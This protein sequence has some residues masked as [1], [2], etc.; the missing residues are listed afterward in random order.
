[1]SRFGI[2][3]ALAMEGEAGDRGT[4][5]VIE[6]LCQ[7]LGVPQEDGLPVP[8]A[9]MGTERM[10]A[11]LNALAVNWLA[12]DGV[13]FQAVERR[14]GMTAA[15]QVNDA[16]WEHFSP[17]EAARIKA[18]TG[19]PANGGL[20]ALASAFIH[21]LYGSINEQEVFFE[22]DGSLVLRM[23]KCRVQAARQRKGLADY[24][25][26]SGGE[27]EYAGFART[28]DPRIACQCIACPPD[29]HPADWFCAWRFTIGATP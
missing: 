23:T 29:P 7:T 27:V 21:R 18:A 22:A 2:E 25:C 12:L 28:I 3:Q 5:I 9:A 26:R 19:L 4:A 11:L 20:E 6:R 14:Q 1:V 15:K 10:Q 17:L 13:W 24:P 16:C 8:L